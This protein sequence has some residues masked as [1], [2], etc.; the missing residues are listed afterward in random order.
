MLYS[1]M[2][3]AAALLAIRFMVGPFRSALATVNS[4]VNAGAAAAVAF[5]LLALIAAGNRA[6]AI[7]LPGPGKV[8]LTVLVI[9][10]AVAFWPNLQSPFVYDDYG[11]IAEASHTT[12]Q[13]LADAFRRFPGGH[14]LFFRPVGFIS[15]WLDYQWA[16][17]H[18]VRW[19][20][21]S[22]AAHAANACLVYFLV[23]RLGIRR[24]AAL[25]AAL[26]FALH[27]SRAETVSWPDARFDLLA[28]LFALC[29]LLAVLEYCRTGR[30]RW[31][32]PLMVCAAL[33]VYTKESAFCLPLLPV[34][35]LPFLPRGQWRRA[36]AASLAL[37]AVCAILFAYRWWALGGIGGYDDSTG[38][39]AIWHSRPLHTL[40]ALLF[41][42]WA[43]LFFPVNWSVPL[44]WWL[45]AAASGFLAILVVFAARAG[46]RREPRY[47]EGRPRLL[48]GLALVLAADIPVQ[49]LLM[50]Q[51]DFA[52][53]RVLYLPLVGFAIF[54]AALLDCSAQSKVTWAMAAALMVFN[55]A[56]LE[57]NLG[58][59]RTT[60]ATAAAVCRGLGGDLANDPR[61][62]FVSGLPNRLHGAYF[63]SNGFPECVEMNSG[64]PAARVH[65]LGGP[66][67]GVPLNGRRFV[68]NS[69]RV[70]LEERR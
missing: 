56:A 24:A 6:A 70:H 36:I 23:T 37:G 2:A 60:P 46:A 13:I 21:W 63:L 62:A 22:I 12:W 34:A 33:A 66:S 64:Q 69:E 32:V 48:A 4:P 49:H 1:L 14:G 27:G 59:W 19:H 3:V 15:Y 20:L 45:R 41:R 68:W 30:R 51:P 57:H 55:V 29:A 53:A 47:M 40:E 38:V 54:W 11:H 65:V 44:E 43:F 18:A 25:V 8:G 31:Y 17:G 9:A 61:P 5:V 50:F 39:S 58:P 52:G 28:T 67:E 16:G 42:Q 26:L 7:A 35:L 10:T